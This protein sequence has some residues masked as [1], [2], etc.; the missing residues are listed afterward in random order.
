[1]IEMKDVCVIGT[2]AAGGVWI[3]AC[4]RAG[5]DVVAIERGPNLGPADFMR[6]DELSN[7]HRGTGFSPAWRDTTRDRASE[8]AQLGRSTMLA[9]C[10]GGGTAHW[11]AWCW[12]FREDD[13]E[14]LSTEG[15]I[16]GAN[17]ADWPISYAELAPFYDAAEIRLGLA[18]EAYANP[19]EP[20]RKSA[21]PN[22]PHPPRS[23]TQAI[24]A[25]AKRLGLHP[26]PTPVAINSRPYQGRSAC[27][28]GGM[29]ANF[30]CPV[31]AK[32]STLAIHVPAALATGR[33]DLRPDCRVIELVTGRD[34]RVSTARTLDASGREREVHAHN[35]VLACGGI[36]SA[37]L[38]LSS[39]SAR[40]P[41]GLANASGLVGRNL[42][43]HNFAFVFFELPDPSMGALG[44]AGMVA[45][46]DLHPSDASR[47]FIR[48][49]VVGESAEP[50]PIWAA[51]K[52]TGYLGADTGAWGKPLK[53]Y[54]RRYPYLAGMVAIGEDL[55]RLD[56]QID[57]DPTHVDDQGIPLA[58]IT[59]ESHRN[60][61]A[62]HDYFDTR[63]HE[64]AR[65]AGATK[66]WS[67]DT[68]HTKGGTG[69][70]MGTCRMGNDPAKSVVDK[71]CRSHEVPNLYIPDGGCFPSSGGYN[72]TLTIFANAARTAQHFLD[73]RK[74]EELA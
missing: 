58:R 12:R 37:H 5:L 30:G 4:T 3:D 66:S 26:F 28:N 52:A 36:G 27:V 41:A 67:V 20:P 61:L 22:P 35:F 33:L 70:I 6:H 13:F 9:H 74:R 71:W 57:L 31:H 72:P 32:A 16:E 8:V 25:G 29:C 64:I 69:H 63:M 47:G 54:L 43:F 44:S 42:M 55:P 46:D 56:N 60:D 45:I 49:A 50:S 34:G 7:I 1:M 18:G 40:H 68:R 19:S 48:G 23:A 38:L 39:R 59:Y 17:L 65:A 11:G 14:V 15:P 73:S 10:V 21:Y 53:D 24:T 51:H 2:G 62:L